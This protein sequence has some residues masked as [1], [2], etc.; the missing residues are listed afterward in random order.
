MTKS[1][2]IFYLCYLNKPLDL[3]N[4]NHF[5]C[6]S[7]G[8]YLTANDCGARYHSSPHP[9]YTVVSVCKH[10]PIWARPWILRWK[11]SKS[12]FHIKIY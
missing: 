2:Q 8:S 10:I 5:I 1:N 11:I 12:L 7:F 3:S 6:K 4:S 9:T